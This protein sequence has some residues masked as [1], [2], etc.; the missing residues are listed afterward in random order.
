[1]KNNM[2]IFKSVSAFL[3]S[4]VM[5]ITGLPG[6]GS[7]QTV[8]A[9]TEVDAIYFKTTGLTDK[10]NSLSEIEEY[11]IWYGSTR[12]TSSIMD[13]L[14]TK[15]GK[16]SYDPEKN[17]LLLKDGAQPNGTHE[18][19]QLYVSGAVDLT[20]DGE[21]GFTNEADYGLYVFSTTLEP[22]I[23][24]KG[25]SL[26]FEG[27]KKAIYAGGANLVFDCE[28]VYAKAEGANALYSVEADGAVSV[29]SGCVHATLT[30]PSSNYPDVIWAGKS[31]T[32][33]GGAVEAYANGDSEGIVSNS[34]VINGGAVNVTAENG[35]ALFGY[36]TG[37][38]I[39]IKDGLVRA[40]GGKGAANSGAVWAQETLTIDPDVDILSP[41]KGT[42]PE[43]GTKIMEPGEEEGSQVVAS[44]ALLAGPS[45]HCDRTAYTADLTEESLVSADGGLTVTDEFYN[46]LKGLDGRTVTCDPLNDTGTEFR[47]DLDKDEKYDIRV[48]KSDNTYI[49]Y[50][51]PGPG[52]VFRLNSVSSGEGMFELEKNAISSG[53][54]GASY[55]G[56][57]TVKVGANYDFGEYTLDFT[58][59]DRSVTLTDIDVI[60][61]ITASVL[62]AA[63]AGDIKISGDYWALKTDIDKD[64]TN[65]LESSFDGNKSV[66]KL[67]PNGSLK[68]NTDMTLSEGARKLLGSEAVKPEYYSVIKFIVEKDPDEPSKPGKGGGGGDEPIKPVLTHHAE[69]TPTMEKDGTKEY[70]EDEKTGKIYSDAEGKNEVTDKNSLI[71]PISSVY[72]VI[73]VKAEG[74]SISMNVVMVRSVSYNSTKHVTKYSKQGKGTTADVE[75]LIKGDFDKFAQITAKDKN[76]KVVPVKPNKTP[77]VILQLKL[78]K[79]VSAEDKKKLKS[80]IK[81][82]NKY[83][84]AHP[85][86]YEIKPAD[87]ERATKFTV[88]T[89]KAKSKVSGLT[90]V[91]DGKELKLSKKDFRLLEIKDGKAVIE[92]MNNFTGK[93]TVE[94]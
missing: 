7:L 72:N 73:D 92:G 71:I 1:M 81:V 63:N 77:S 2:R 89:N 58:N 74:S 61:R 90:A 46:T 84:K 75:I 78:K 6:V 80:D 52:G 91:V 17:T 3:M 65:D 49:V 87:L 31:F 70:W 28:E 8:S 26:E 55:Y 54:T 42:V 59:D 94:L 45:C 13:N 19:A 66:I 43:G 76:N 60:R 44:E 23:T 27:K 62:A 41:E 64:G 11:P 12:I 85:F 50:P 39:T 48:V 38:S 16:A 51:L 83:L 22:T 82:I 24:L 36:S 33:D 29:K 10:K 40:K 14:P 18:G 34:I 30:D 56:D 15:K 32:V 37:G 35:R 79:G 5:M 69:V 4:A 57:L 53:A 25:T 67:L 93:V 47:C 68:K 20:I 86:T 88:K 9:A 21:G